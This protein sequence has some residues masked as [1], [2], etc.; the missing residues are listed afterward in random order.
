MGLP[1]IASVP[2]SQFLAGPGPIYSGIPINGN[3][4]PLS[5]DSGRAVTGGYS[6]TGFGEGVGFGEGMGDC[7]CPEPVEVGCEVEEFVPAVAQPEFGCD[8]GIPFETGMTNASP[9]A[10]ETASTVETSESSE[11]A[12]VVEATEAPTDISDTEEVD[13][14]IEKADSDDH[15]IKAVDMAES[16]SIDDVDHDDE[17]KR[18]TFLQRMLNWILAPTNMYS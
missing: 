3:A 18:P 14:T 5:L 13:E 10:A 9:W 2:I 8:A 16:Q 1:P 7:G 11:T 15:L 4:D 12:D 17:L 6:G